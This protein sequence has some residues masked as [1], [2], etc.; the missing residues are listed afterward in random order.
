MGKRLRTQRRGKGKGRYVAPSTRYYSEARY[1]DAASLQGR[2]LDLV[3]DPSKYG[4][5]M[6]VQWNDGNTG[7]YLAPEGIAVGDTVKQGAGDVSIG[8]VLRLSDIPEGMPIFNVENVPGDGGRAV[9][10]SG[11]TA[12]I[13]AK[14]PGRVD[15]RLPSKAVKTFN[16]DCRAMIGVSAAGGR[17]DKPLVKAGKSFYK[18]QS[19]GHRWPSV[20]GV[21]M[22]PVAHPH[23]GKEHH[24]GKATTVKRGTP[25]GRNV[26][27]IAARRTG[28]RK[29]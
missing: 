1:R 20:R 10:S 3:K 11:A 7:Y 12:F 16:P 15:V 17:P 22:N 28:R 8:S 26:G 4:L 21:A 19:R 23:G 5:L 27:H 2:V 14:Q 25:P 9:R 24:S 18:W 29:R 13:V 6:R